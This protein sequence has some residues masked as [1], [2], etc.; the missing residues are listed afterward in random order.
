MTLSALGYPLRS[1]IF[2]PFTAGLGFKLDSGTLD[3]AWVYRRLG[4]TYRISLG[5]NWGGW[6]SPDKDADLDVINGV[7]MGSGGKGGPD[8]ELQPLVREPHKV[9]LV[10]LRPSLANAPATV[11]K[12][13]KGLGPFGSSLTWDAKSDSGQ[14]L[15]DGTYQAILSVRLKSG[16]IVNS[17]YKKLLLNPPLPEASLFIDNNSLV[18]GQPDTVFVPSDFDINVVRNITNV[19]VH[20]RAEMQDSS[21]RVFQVVEGPS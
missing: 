3:L 14:Q 8:F 17:F 12:R 21:S 15:P 9:K 7:F 6:V 16:K 2:N 20:W 4:S 11:V 10:G 5:Y 19:P 1:Q 18:L 13:F